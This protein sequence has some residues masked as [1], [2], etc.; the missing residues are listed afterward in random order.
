MGR[1]GDA[2]A[3]AELIPVGLTG[4]GNVNCFVYVV[5]FRIKL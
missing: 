5:Q 2:L 3:Y 1:G 4:F